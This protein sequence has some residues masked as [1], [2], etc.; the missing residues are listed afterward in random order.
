MSIYV[1]M[2]IGLAPLGNFE[3]GWLSEKAGT[4]F[5]IRLGAIIVF[6]FA[7]IVFLRRNKITG[8]FNKYQEQGQ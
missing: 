6:I 5:A 2:F 7:F 1:F 8:A 3:I 4:S